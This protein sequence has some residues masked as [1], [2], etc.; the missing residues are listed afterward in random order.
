MPAAGGLCSGK[1]ETGGCAA[2]RVK[3]LT[4]KTCLLCS[5]CQRFVHGYG[6]YALRDAQSAYLVLSSPCC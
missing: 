3:H 4:S 5:A 2:G 6:T 1:L